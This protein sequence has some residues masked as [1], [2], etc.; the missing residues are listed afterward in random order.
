MNVRS[1]LHR[2]FAVPATAP[3]SIPSQR[4]VHLR[5]R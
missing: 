2:G 5:H 3:L 1:H 4:L